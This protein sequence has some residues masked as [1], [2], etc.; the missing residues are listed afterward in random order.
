M[1]QT[2]FAEEIKKSAFY[3]QQISFPPY[4]LQFKMWTNM[5]DQDRPQVKIWCMRIARWIPKAA[6]T[7]SEH[8]TL[9]ASPRQQF[10]HERSSMLR[11]YVHLWSVYFYSYCCYTWKERTRIS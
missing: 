11:V 9:I 8:V 1:F 4:T 7:H 10:L 6:N 3:V 5:A 2:K